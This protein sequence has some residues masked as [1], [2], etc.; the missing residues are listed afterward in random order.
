MALLNDPEVVFL[1]ELTQGLDPPAR[2]DVWNAILAVRDRGATVVL[3]SHMP[4]EVEVLCDR[5][6]VMQ[7]GRVIDTDTPAGLID[8]HARNTTVV[9]FTP[10]TSFEPTALD[11]VPGVDQVERQGDR[12]TVRGGSARSWLPCVRRAAG[13]PREPVHPTCGCTTRSLTMHC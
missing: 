8:R 12:Y 11:R 3:V 7:G 9:T 10:P 2:R 1:D 5:V 6:A 13:R 4:D